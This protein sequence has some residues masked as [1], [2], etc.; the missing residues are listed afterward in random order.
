MSQSNG[1]QTVLSLD[2]FTLLKIIEILKEPVFM[3]VIPI[4]SYHIRIKERDLTNV[5]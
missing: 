2:H 5:W 3:W 4:N 1:S